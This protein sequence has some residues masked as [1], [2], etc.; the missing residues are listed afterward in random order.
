MGRVWPPVTGELDALVEAD[1]VRRGVDVG[2]LA[3]R[4]QHGLE[5]RGGGALAV[6]AGNMNDRRETLLRVAQLGEQRL[7]AAERKVDQPRVQLSQLGQEL[8]AR[9]HAA[10]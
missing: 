3:R 7:D 5:E 6:G 2:P 8:V 4:L 9:A 1:E 10:P